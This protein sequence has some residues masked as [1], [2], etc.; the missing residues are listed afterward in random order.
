[1]YKFAAIQPT[2]YDEESKNQSWNYSSIIAD[3]TMLFKENRYQLGLY[4]GGDI[5]YLHPMQP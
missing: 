1:M 2:P 3:D 4:G 5:M